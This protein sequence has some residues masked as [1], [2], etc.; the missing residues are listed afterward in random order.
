MT[1]L[2]PTA[3]RSSFPE[4]SLDGRP[5]GGLARIS[6]AVRLPHGTPRFIVIAL[7][8]GSAA[9]ERVGRGGELI[10]WLLDGDPAAAEPASCTAPAAAPTS[11]PGH[12]D[13]VPS[14]RLPATASLQ[15]R[16]QARRPAGS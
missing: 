15:F 5:E 10:D 7:A 9:A 3:A 11:P 14:P 8:A 13:Q 12:P 1:S 6:I 16:R 2:N 4:F